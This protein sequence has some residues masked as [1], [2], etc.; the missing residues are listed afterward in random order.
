[1]SGKS[2]VARKTIYFLLLLLIII[3]FLSLSLAFMILNYYPAG[4]FSKIVLSTAIIFI[5]LIAIII[6]QA[7]ANRKIVSRS[8]LPICHDMIDEFKLCKRC[9]WLYIGLALFGA[10]IAV[11]NYIYIDLL[12][13]FG[14]YPY[15]VLMFL[16]LFSVPLHGALRRLKIIH[17]ERL[18]SIVGFIFGSSPYLVASWLIFLIYG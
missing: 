17:R 18:L 6:V 1:M 13:Y 5:A 10:L 3:C 12:R 9:I 11:R 4:F 7:V 15:T 8:R 16:V 2:T 14:F